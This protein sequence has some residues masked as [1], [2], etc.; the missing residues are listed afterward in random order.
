VTGKLKILI[1]LAFFVFIPLS[2]NLLAQEVQLITSVDVEGNERIDKSSI[3][4][5]ISLKTG[6]PFDSSSITSSVRA[7]YKMGVFE[8]VSIEEEI[9]GSGVRI[10]VVVREY[11][12]VR[13]VVISGSDSV[14]ETE[15]KKVLK[16]KVFSFYDPAKIAAEIEALK[17]VYKAKGY[18]KAE[19]NNE[20]VTTERGVEL[21]YTIHEGEKTL[22]TEIDIIGNRVLT[23]RAIRKVIQVK[24]IGPL[25]FMSDSGGFN[26]TYMKNDL[27][28]IKMLYMEDGY[29]D[30]T[31][32]EP[33]MRLH[34]DGEG[35]YLAIKVDEGRQYRIGKVEYSGEWEGLPPFARRDPEVGSGDVFIRS[36]V[37]QDVRM[38]E[39]SHRDQGYARC[40]VDPQLNPD[41]EKGLVNI[42]LVLT[43]GP[44]VHV[45]WIEISGNYK[46][47]D[48]VVRREMR[49]VEGDLYDQ[50]KLDESRRY[51]R[52]LGFFNS[53]EVK[54]TDVG[55]T[56]ADI[57]V[58]VVDGSSG[59]FSAGAAYSS[60]DGLIGTLQLAL[61]NFMGRGQ[62]LNIDTEL[63]GETST[64]SASFTEPRLFS[65]NFSLGVDVF[66]TS[67][68]YTTYTQD[69]RGGSIR[70]GYRITDNSSANMRYRYADYNVFD[71][72]ED[73]TTV[74]K[75]S[76]GINTTSS[77]RL[78][79]SYDTR[80]YAPD[81][82]EGWKINLS[83][84]VA[85]GSLGG[86]N[87]FVRTIFEGSYYHPIYKDVIGLVHTELGV[88]NPFG[89]NEI[90]L[91]E[92]FFLGGLYTV[93]GFEHRMVGPLEDGEPIG[94]TKSFLTNFEASIPVVK[95]AGIKAVT[96][97]DIGNVWADGED[98]DLDDTRI[99]AGFGF[100][101][102]SPMGLLRLEWGFNLDPEPDE[103][104]P[105]WEFSI[106]TIF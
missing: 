18:Y 62:S 64:Y 52:S 97:L 16:V 40:R 43:K 95:E 15:L 102:A 85:G 83:N 27:Q 103:R 59:T 105:G 7:L 57:I 19:V 32:S 54:V 36:K 9:E 67:K 79:Y 106:G 61:K 3:K 35:L 31:I 90:P 92:R 20:V 45:R 5:K 34:P 4:S 98:V 10:R 80:D 24:E 39:N 87:D 89:G 46:T 58:K 104:S 38:L 42:D 99:G 33:E 50:K 41:F 23:D 37:F 48:Y 17:R 60:I 71:V 96:F 72:D 8:R 56:E 21:E 63:G 93:R 94:G 49:I 70:F 22:I 82:R 12:M 75:D 13:K 91:T 78:G 81:P 53:V 44:L 76:E 65:G 28:R 73:A 55:E 100:R 51:I 6:E 1:L 88:I 25:S 68:E 69:S 101:W 77:I 29:L 66:D 11:P 2:S 30:V 47:R 74:I 84:E 14:K 86:T 26:E